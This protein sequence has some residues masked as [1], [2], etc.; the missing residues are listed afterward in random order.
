MKQPKPQLIKTDFLEY[1]PEFSETPEHLLMRSL[2]DAI[3][4]TKGSIWGAYKYKDYTCSTRAKAIFHHAAH[5]ITIKTDG[6]ASRSSA[7]AS[8]SLRG[9]SVSY[10][11][12]SSNTELYT[13]FG[14]TGYGQDY[15]I[16]YDKLS[17][18]YV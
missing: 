3:A 5:N 8:K 2:A 15:L 16:L 11:G 9:V 13:S 7:I 1:Y 12:Q 14:S 18:V 17:M 10:G 4:T 6:N